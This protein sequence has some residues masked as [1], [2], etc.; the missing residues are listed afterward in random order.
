MT[1]CADAYPVLTSAPLFP[2]T[3]QT[4]PDSPVPSHESLGSWLYRFC[5]SNGYQDIN[6]TF[7]RS[8]GNR[9]LSMGAS[10]DAPYKTQVNIELIA[11]VTN[12]PLKQ[13]ERLMLG[14][15]LLAF[16][17]KPNNTKGQWILR[18]GKIE[19]TGPWMRHVICPLCAMD[20]ADPFWLQSWRLSTT[21]E[22]RLHKIM[23]LENCP[24]CAAH[25][26]IHSKR[27]QSL[28]RCECCNLHFSEMPVEACKITNA[29]PDFA[30]RAGHNQPATLPVA[31]SNEF[32]WWRGVRQML[33]HIEDPN[34]AGMLAQRCL[35]DEFQ[36]LLLHIS[37][38]AKHC[39]DDWSIQHRHSA[40]R[41]IE[42]LTTSWPHKFVNL[43]AC[44]GKIY[45][46]ARYLTHTE[47]QWIKNAF[48]QLAIRA[49]STHTPYGKLQR[50]LHSN[51]VTCLSITIFKRSQKSLPRVRHNSL[52]NHW[53]PDYTVRVIRALDAR[54]LAMSGSVETKSRF[55]RGAAAIIL[56]RG[57]LGHCIDNN[58]SAAQGEP[59]KHALQTVNA[60][61]SCVHHLHATIESKRSLPLQQPA[62]R[63][64]NGHLT[65][66]L[67]C[68]SLHAQLPLFGWTEQQT[69]NQ[70]SAVQ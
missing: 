33:S 29:A 38:N 36:E 27:N 59:L 61:T 60:W 50:P 34:R 67:G 24:N 37:L 2:I 26:V 28:D 17:G 52:A 18:S 21:T 53:S 25:F 54:V 56:K 22:C 65:K 51:S 6:S 10:T 12:V 39:F 58:S 42:W 3:P 1:I 63:L 7:S 66:W 45:K 70:I 35:P 57:A 32:H 15:A 31:Q 23:L 43:L 68:E 49:S 46:P 4:I 11:T 48:G 19:Q 13:V 69:G 62:M 64:N 47:P 5:R 14:Q 8:A 16:Q 44:T 9:A 30:R 20:S 41:F 55:V 40:L